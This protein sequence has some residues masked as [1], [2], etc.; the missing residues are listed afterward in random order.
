VSIVDDGGGGSCDP[1]GHGLAGMRERVSM[2]GGELEAGA[3]PG[4]GWSVR[5]RLP[6]PP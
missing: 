1:A 5:A 4:G 2:Y 6:A 3:A